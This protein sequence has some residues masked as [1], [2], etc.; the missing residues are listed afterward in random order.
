M[1]ALSMDLPE[2]VVAAH[3]RL[4]DNHSPATAWAP[5]RMGARPHAGGVRGAW[6]LF[7]RRR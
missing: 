1:V 2:R 6:R 5:G 3:H 4:V 7:M